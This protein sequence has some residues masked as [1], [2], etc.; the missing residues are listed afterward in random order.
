MPIAFLEGDLNMPP[1]RRSR[2][3]PIA[4]S[5][6]G[7]AV[8]DA[9]KRKHE[10]EKATTARGLTAGGKATTGSKKKKKKKTK[11]KASQKTQAKSPK[12]RTHSPEKKA[13]RKN[14]TKKKRNLAVVRRD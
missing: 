6:S 5:G 8:G 10:S 7:R 4:I 2:G 12:T 14:G 1:G 3:G 11:A 9:L 13:R